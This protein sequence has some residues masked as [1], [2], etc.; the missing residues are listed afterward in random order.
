MNTYEPARIEAKWQKYWKDNRLFQLD[1]KV[2]EKKYYCLV[3]FIYPSAD[4]L[5][6]GHWYCY[7]P[8]DT[9]ARYKKMCGMRVFEPMGYDAFGLPAEN[10]AISQGVHPAKSTGE[11]ID[12]IRKQL[13]A[14]GAMYDW[15]SEIDTSSPSYYKWTQWLFLQLYRAGLAY[16]KQ[17]PVNW[18]P[19]CLT[20][21]ANEQVIDGMCERCDSAVTK[22]NMRQWFFKITDYAERLLQDLSKLDWPEKTKLMQRNWIGKSKGVEIKFAADADSDIPVFTTRPDTLFGATY[23]VLA[24][25]HPLLEQLTSEDRE[26]DVS[27]YAEAT[28]RVSEIERS[29][30]VRE[31]SGVFIGSYAVNPINGKKVPIWIS[32]YVVL[33]YG[34]GA[35]MAVPA[36]DERDF[37][38]ATMF[39]LPVERVI[40]KEGED[41][42]SPVEA[43]YTG[44]GTMM[45]SASFDGLPSAPAAEKITEVLEKKGLA[46]RKINYKLRDWLISRQRYWGAPIPIIHCPH[47]GEVAVPE[48]D[49]PV[50]L[51]EKVEFTPSKDSSHASPLASAEAFVNVKCP[52]CGAD[53][54]RET[55]TMDT[56]VCSSWYYLRYVN[57]H[58]DKGPFDP[59]LVKKWLPVDHYVGGAEHAVMHL[60]YARFITKALHDLKFLDFEEPFTKLVHQGTITKDGAKMSKSR[61]NV[62]NPDSFVS[63]YGSDIFRMY[64]MFTGPYEDGGDWNDRGITGISRYLRRVWK[65]ICENEDFPSNTN[66]RQGLLRIEHKTIRRVTLSMEKFHFNTALSAL[67]EYANYLEDEREKICRKD[68]KECVSTLILLLAPFC[69]HLGEELWEKIGNEPSVFSKNWP[70]WDDGLAQEIEKV[71]AVQ[72]NGKLRGTFSAPAGLGKGKLEEKAFQVES[73]K[74]FIEGKNIKKVIVVPDRIV[75]VV[76]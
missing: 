59:E 5:H 22:K 32:D 73:V 56:F 50:E 19:K 75:N 38:F 54:E 21:L 12:C 65:I 71:I 7:G 43:V 57:P 35:I 74:K 14:I 25:E 48:K 68:Y 36:H 39:N 67:M 70:E 66:D 45:N 47:C 27:A 28:K 6:I 8:T 33:S 18:C 46:V 49:L 34:T 60:L 69:P 76:V 41:E 51:P 26:K 24:P 64:L 11:N 16:K 2:R 31:K 20:V 72:V 63:E 13:K 3:M 42:N 58:Y 61:G 10:Y 9:W 62:V 40:L 17:A 15:E 37:E 29:S 55:D 52:V 4:K 44:E 53:A 1:M 30:T 23:L